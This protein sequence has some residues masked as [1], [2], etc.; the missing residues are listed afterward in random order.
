[1]SR[2]P[3]KLS[4]AAVRAANPGAKSY[5]LSDGGGL[6]LVVDPS[7]AKRWTFLF[8][9]G[10]KLKE[11]GLGGATSVTLARA[12][13]KAAL[14]RAL[15]ADGKNPVEERRRAKLKS[16]EVSEHLPTPASG[17][18]RDGDVVSHLPPTIEARAPDATGEVQ[19]S[20]AQD[21]PT[22]IGPRGLRYDFNDGARV[23]LPADGGP[24]RVRLSDLDTGNTLYETEIN[25][26]SV[27][28]SKRYYVRF[29][30][31][32]WSVGELVLTH[33]FEARDRDVLVRFPVDTLGDTVGWFSYAAKFQKAHGCR[34]TCA[35]A[36]AIIPLFRDAYP[37]IE[38]VS[39]TAKQDRSY[40]ATYSP[41]LY[42][43][44]HDH[45]HQPCD[46]QQTG[47]HRNAG[48]ILGV[49][50]AEERPRIALVEA[51]RPI[52]EPYVCIA[53]QST[54]QCKYWNN[55]RGWRQVVSFLEAAGYRVVCIDQKDTH[56]AGLVWNHIPHGV[57]DETGSRPLLE[58]ANWIRHA[59][60]FVGL[61]SGLSWLAWA[62]DVPVVMISGFTHPINE[63]ATPYRVINYHTCNSCFNDIRLPLDKTD[64]LW[65]PRHAGTPRQFE[66]TRL[67]TPEQVTATIRK[68]PGF[69]RHAG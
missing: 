45:R 60:F 9:W 59:A 57:R 7:S 64:F 6:Y 61:S 26:G 33:D 21:A 54:A 16:S 20:G 18:P 3:G 50:L 39:H 41:V 35:M 12:R 25:S 46:Y 24:W 67:I 1:M 10:G 40:Y 5:K 62:L 52:A 36:E 8:R 47:L 14:C 2:R 30:L 15:V 34:M 32:A 63:F 66:C 55:P 28:S 31:E 29:R 53:T 69:G 48:A 58:R 19:D 43:N 11:M 17:M 13:E 38:F 65:C 49:D 27:N 42:F 68:I 22:Q 44:D 56:G 4:A 51:G 37:D 23:L